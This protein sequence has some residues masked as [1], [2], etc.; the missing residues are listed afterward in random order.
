MQIE[1][2]SITNFHQLSSQ[3]LK[4]YSIFI[5]NVTSDVDLWTMMQGRTE[6][7]Q[8]FMT[9]FKAVM[10]KAGDVTCHCRTQEGALVSV[11]LSQEIAHNPP[12]TIQDAIHRSVSFAVKE[13]DLKSLAKIHE[14][15]K[16]T[17]KPAPTEQYAPNHRRNNQRGGYVH[18]EG[19]NLSGSHNYQVTTG[20][21]VNAG[22]QAGTGRGKMWNTWT[23][24]PT[25]YDKEAYCEHHQSYGHSTEKCRSLGALLAKKLLSGELGSEVTL[26]YLE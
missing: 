16:P 12:L 26:K 11:G 8:N 20:E 4:Q 6:T 17:P 14:P 25:T 23:R 24:N 15:S 22:F 18:H 19:P 7:L 21:Q 10:A 2:N 5:E 3:F 9:R 13:E 1:P